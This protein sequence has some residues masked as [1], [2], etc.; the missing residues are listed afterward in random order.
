MRRRARDRGWLGGDNLR[1]VGPLTCVAA[2]GLR[3]A[4]GGLHESPSRRPQRDRVRFPVPRAL[5]RHPGAL[6]RPG[7]LRHALP[8]APGPGTVP[9]RPDPAYVST[10]S[11]TAL[12]QIRSWRDAY[13][14][15]VSAAAV[16]FAALAAALGDAGVPV[17]D[18][19]VVVLVDARRYLPAGGPGG[20]H[21]PLGPVPAPRAPAH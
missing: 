6:L 14:P 4:L 18:R 17:A 9:W 20:G 3:A 19:G 11:D 2:S 5:L 12:G 13:A 16:Q 21:L 1:V 7:R 15:G 10:S 8:P